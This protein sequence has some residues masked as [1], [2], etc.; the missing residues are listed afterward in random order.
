[1]NQTDWKN[2]SIISVTIDLSL[3]GGNDVEEMTLNTSI[4]DVWEYLLTTTYIPAGQY[5]ISIRATSSSGGL[6]S[7]EKFIVDVNQFNP[8]D[9]E[10]KEYPTNK[11]IYIKITSNE[12]IIN[13]K[14]NTKVL[15]DINVEGYAEVINND[16]KITQIDLYVYKKINDDFYFTPFL[17]RNGNEIS[18]KNI[19]KDGYWEYN[20]SY[21][22]DI[23]YKYVCPSCKIDVGQDDDVCWYCSKTIAP[24]KLE[25][26]FTD[27]E[28][29]ISNRTDWKVIAVAWD[30]DNLF[31]YNEGN[32]SWKIKPPVKAKEVWDVWC[33]GLIIILGI[34]L[35]FCAISGSIYCGS[36]GGYILG[37]GLIIIPIYYCY[38]NFTSGINGPEFFLV[39][40]GL[41]IITSLVDL[42]VP[43]SF[44]GL[45][46]GSQLITLGGLIGVILYWDRITS[47]WIAFGVFLFIYL[48][49]CSVAWLRRK[50]IFMDCIKGAQKRRLYKRTYAGG[51]GF[52]SPDLRHLGN[53]TDEEL[54]EEIEELLRRRYK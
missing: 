34:F 16:K 45:V 2:F 44:V 27:F 11:N 47:T 51:E 31:N 17:D 40:V 43:P 7:T 36:P 4:G 21:E 46:G 12:Y 29:E 38:V 54:R 10:G 48:S 42:F 50:D 5:T 28:V 19:T 26:T 23:R 1:V 14:S 41:G 33:F 32:I 30:E 8:I 25:R 49:V 35:G 20:E 53:T 52:G 39:I 24:Q 37:F 13:G 6:N 18:I 3:I 15:I 22:L 9:F